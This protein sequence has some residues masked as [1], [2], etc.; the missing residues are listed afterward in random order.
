MLVAAKK[1]H[2]KIYT[3]LVLLSA[4][5]CKGMEDLTLPDMAV[6]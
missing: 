4:L 3:V 1:T 2:S 6:S 5:L